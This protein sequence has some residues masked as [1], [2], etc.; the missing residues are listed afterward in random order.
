G[1]PILDPTPWV[2]GVKPFLIQS[3]SQFRSVPPPA[4]DSPQW[5]DEFNE[6]KDL[7]RFD[8]LTRTADQTYFARWWQSAPVLSWNEVARQLIARNDLDA[9]DSAR[10]LALQ[11]LSA[12]DAVINAWND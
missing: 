4:L 2:G 7:G 9:A 11:N 10:L 12:A 3:S 8:S 5:A 1:Q 6:V